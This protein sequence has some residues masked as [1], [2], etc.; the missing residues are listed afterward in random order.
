ML[1]RI[2]RQTLGAARKLGRKKLYLLILLASSSASAAVS[3][4]KYA[5]EIVEKFSRMKV[6]SDSMSAAVDGTKSTHKLKPTV[7][8]KDAS[9]SVTRRPVNVNG[10]SG[11]TFSEITLV[12]KAGK[13]LAYGSGTFLT[14]PF[15]IGASFESPMPPH[16]R[17]VITVDSTSETAP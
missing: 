4:Q 16:D 5:I 13:E 14:G 12:D 2:C 15:T 6:F 11:F 1:A 8:L 17:L 9:L 10:K 3:N 7:V